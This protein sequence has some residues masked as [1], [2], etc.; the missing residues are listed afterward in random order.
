MLFRLLTFVT[1]VAYASIDTFVKK[2]N[3]YIFNPI[4]VFLV[5]VALAYFLY[6]IL[7]FIQ[8]LDNET[9]RDKGK[10]H[11]MWGLIGLFIMVSVFFLMRVILGSVGIDENEINPQ[12][13]EVNIT[14]QQ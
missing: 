9:A 2:L 1:P 8:G 11:I 5:I 14:T 13:G 6:G 12:T 4:I 3:T 10:Q 7:E